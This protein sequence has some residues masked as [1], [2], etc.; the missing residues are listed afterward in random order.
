M[1]MLMFVDR[2]K[3]RHVGE[4]YEKLMGFRASMGQESSLWPPS[5]GNLTREELQWFSMN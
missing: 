1:L 4:F 5:D 2:M 3:G